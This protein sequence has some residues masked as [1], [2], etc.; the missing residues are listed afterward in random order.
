[1]SEIGDLHYNIDTATLDK[2]S[3]WNDFRLVLNIEDNSITYYNY[4]TPIL[5]VDGQF[6]S[7]IVI[8]ELKRFKN[9]NSSNDIIK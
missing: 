8:A 9:L 1:M 3:Y 2:S 7:L 5:S 6:K 4:Y